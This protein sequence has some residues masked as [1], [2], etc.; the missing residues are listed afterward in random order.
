MIFL[1]K[2]KFHF[3]FPGASTSE[4]VI[5]GS[6]CKWGEGSLRLFR[7]KLEIG[8]AKEDA[9]N[10]YLLEGHTVIENCVIASPVNT[11]VYVINKDL[12]RPTSLEVNYCV[13]DGMENAERLFCFEVSG[14]N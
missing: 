7:L 4:T 14:E 8:V 12:F 2:A 9:S 11:A 1:D 10:A 6:L 13:V 3:F 5:S